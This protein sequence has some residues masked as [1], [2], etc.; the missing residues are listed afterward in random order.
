V[1]HYDSAWVETASIVIML[2]GGSNFVLWI[3]LVR[4]G[5]REA[6]VQA[7]SSSELRFYLALIAAQ[8][9]LVTLVL[10]FWG[11]ANGQVGT[12][13]PDY[14]RFLRCLRD[15]AFSV[16][17]LQTTTGLATADFDLWPSSCRILLMMG[18]LMGACAGSTGGGAKLWRVLVTARASL[19]SVRGFVRPRAVA[20]V[21]VDG[22]SLADSQVSSATRFFALWVFT[23]MVGSIVLAML[24]VGTTEAITG[25]IACL[26]TTGPGLGRLGPSQN[27]G[28]L[29]DA[30]KLVLEALMLLGRLEFYAL[31]SLFMPG[32]WR[33]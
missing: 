18:A 7:R 1:G 3:V 6:L 32:L 15:S 26:N 5:P 22:K 31:I 14:T 16:V 4:R 2:A 23:G 29:S 12:G 10:W 24:G 17:T 19:A 33:T 30:S 28:H 8:V 11:G 9:G 21:Q 20:V 25:V 13:L 27:F